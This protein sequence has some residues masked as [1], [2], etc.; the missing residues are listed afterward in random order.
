MLS[1]IKNWF[2]NFWGSF[3]GSIV[4]QAFSAVLAQAG[5]MAVDLL[6]AQAMNEVAKLEGSPLPGEVKAKEARKALTA[7]AIKQGLTVTTSLLNYVIEN[8]VQALKS[9]E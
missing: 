1:A 2:A 6:A 7:F 3:A 9:K 8:A 4:K 5:T